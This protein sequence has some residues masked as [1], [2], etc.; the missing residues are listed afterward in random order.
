MRRSLR[1]EKLVFVLK[2]TDSSRAILA[3]V[4]LLGIEKRFFETFRV[5]SSDT[6]DL[7]ISVASST[8]DEEVARLRL[9]VDGAFSFKTKI[10]F[11]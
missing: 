8:N 9:S 3:A 4:E 6:V 5:P 1:L 2:A 10:Q 7:L 11:E